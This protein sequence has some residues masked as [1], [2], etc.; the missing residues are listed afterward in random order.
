MTENNINA[1]CSICNKGY[2]ICNSCAE[3][4]SLKPWR[5]VT[6]TIE[7]YKIYLAIHGYTLSKDKESAK[8]ELES[9]DLSGLENF[10]PEIKSVIKE[11]LTEPKKKFVSK[12]EKNTLDIKIDEVK[13]IETKE[14]DII[15]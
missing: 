14:N 9:C 4:K 12:K 5:S 2:H 7:H 3:Q 6:D 8:K 15:E 11:I 10:N 13:E 1:H